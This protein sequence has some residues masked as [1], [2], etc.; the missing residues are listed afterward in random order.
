MHY[1]LFKYNSNVLHTILV[2]GMNLRIEKIWQ[3]FESRRFLRL[4]GPSTIFLMC[5][6][7]LR[8][9][10]C[11]KCVREVCVLW[12]FEFMVRM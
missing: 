1:Y 9:S 6:V 3:D 10:I 12:Y 7:C 8:V 11:M 2:V 5:I 4:H